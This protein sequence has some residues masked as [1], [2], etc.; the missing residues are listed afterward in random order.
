MAG[1]RHKGTAVTGKSPGK[2]RYGGKSKARC[3]DRADYNRRGKAA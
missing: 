1:K 2:T 3:L